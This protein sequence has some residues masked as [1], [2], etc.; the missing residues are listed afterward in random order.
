[1]YSVAINGLYVSNFEQFVLDIAS[2]FLIAWIGS[3][4]HDIAEKFPSAQAKLDVANQ[5]ANLTAVCQFKEQDIRQ[6]EFFV[7]D[8]N[9]INEKYEPLVSYTFSLNG[10]NMSNSEALMGYVMSRMEGMQQNKARLEYHQQLAQIMIKQ[11]ADHGVTFG[12]ADMAQ[13]VF[14][15]LSA[16]WF[17]VLSAKG[18]L[19]LREINRLAKQSDQKKVVRPQQG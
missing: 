7:F 4:R 1:M 18:L 3:W 10:L 5:N 8:L 17:E 14:H 6:I 2:D 19:T 16:C 9:T 12:N 13:R 15:L 11:L